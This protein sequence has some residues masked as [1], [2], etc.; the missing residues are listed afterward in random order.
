MEYLPN[1]RSD[2]SSNAGGQ[3]G[4]LTGNQGAGEGGNHYL[5]GQVVVAVNLAFF[6]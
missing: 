3:G 1:R 4:N 5:P 2:E 6:L